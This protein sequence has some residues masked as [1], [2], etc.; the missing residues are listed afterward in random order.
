VNT[1]IAGSYGSARD[2]ARLAGAL[3]ARAPDIALATTYPEA[4][5]TSADGTI[6][7]VKNTDPIVGEVPRLLLSKTGYTS[8]AGGN[9]AL[10]FDAA[11]GH[12]I[13]VVVLG[14]SK[15]SRFTDGMALV[16]A[17]LTHFATVPLR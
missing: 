4:R 14:S 1:A 15:G 6:Y 2:I 7:R 3:A 12:P 5:A 13:A 11:I 16:T 8:L 9:L 17:A 10:V